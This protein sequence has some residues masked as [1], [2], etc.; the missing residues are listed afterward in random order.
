LDGGFDTVR[1][2]VL[3]WYTPFLNRFLTNNVE[4]LKD[5]KSQLQEYLQR[6]QMSLPTYV[7]EAVE[8]KIHQQQFVVRCYI[9]S[10]DATVCGRG[11]NRRRA[12]QDAA[13]KMLG[14]IQH[15]SNWKN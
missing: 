2:C 15:E 14:L 6:H 4:N 5:P 1:E 3:R 13:V 12:E 11:S 7:I 10:I 9:A 8:G